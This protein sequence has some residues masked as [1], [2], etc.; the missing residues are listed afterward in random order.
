[1][2]IQRWSS[3]RRMRLSE[4]YLD[5]I[6]QRIG[7]GELI[8]VLRKPKSRLISSIGSA[9]NVLHNC[10]PTHNISGLQELVHLLIL[11]FATASCTPSVSPALLQLLSRHRLAEI[12]TSSASASTTNFY[13]REVI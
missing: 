2:M 12:P 9:D 6:K 10:K 1:M 5:G 8:G 4:A 3:F 7:E 11:L 13:H